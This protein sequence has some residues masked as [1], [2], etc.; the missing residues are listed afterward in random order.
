LQIEGNNPGCRPDNR[1]RRREN[2]RRIKMQSIF[3]GIKP[4]E[5]LA[6]IRHYRDT[7]NDLAR[8]RNEH[9]ERVRRLNQVEHIATIQASNG[10]ENWEV[11]ITKRAGEYYEICGRSTRMD[12]YL[13][14]TV[15]GN[16]LVSVLNCQRAGLVPEDCNAGDIIEYCDFDNLTDATTL[17]TAIRYLIK[18]GLID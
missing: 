18:Q 13:R 9:L 10:A 17:A 3:E 14:E 15:H 1:G 7:A 11:K 12:L 16:Y 5:T 6:L 2:G 4:E 8:I